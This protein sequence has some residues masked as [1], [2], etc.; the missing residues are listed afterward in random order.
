MMMIGEHFY[1]HSRPNPSVQIPQRDLYDEQTTSPS[2]STIPSSPFTSFSALDSLPA[3]HRYLPSNEPDPSFEDEL[4][5]PVDAFSCDHFRMYVFK[6]RRC[7]RGR[8]H[9]WTEC[10]YAHPGEKARRRDPQRYNYSGTACPEFRKG[11]CKKGDSCEFAHG[12]FECWLH[13]A[14]YRTQPFLKET[15]P[16]PGRGKLDFGSL[17]VHPLDSYLTN[18]GSFVS[19]PTSILTSPPVSPPSDSPPMSP[20]SPGMIGGS[21]SMAFNSTGELVAS[22][23]G[24]QLGKMTIGSPVDSWGVQSGSSFG[25][26]RRSS[27]RP[28]FCSLP[29]TP[30]RKLATRS[31]LGQLDIWGDI[32]T[33]EEPVMERV[34]SGRD[35]EGEDILKAK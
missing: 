26:S 28:G 6:V 4:D 19:S 31:G 17:A 13:P 9:D 12:V 22:M 2:P 16:G 20:V 34:E 14:R 23:R 11:G 15:G 1:P 32:S 29:S 30:T 7:G 24:L 25:S 35:F 5:L 10:P 3:L 18:A 8:S 33:C 21:G 27:L